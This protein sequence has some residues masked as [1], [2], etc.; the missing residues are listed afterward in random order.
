MIIGFLNPPFIMHEIM[1]YA[2]NTRARLCAGIDV[3]LF[4]LRKRILAARARLDMAANKA[5]GCIPRNLYMTKK[6]HWVR[7]KNR[8]RTL[9]TLRRLMK[10]RSSPRV[11]SGP[12]PESINERDMADRDVRKRMGITLK[13]IILYHTI[14]K[15][16]IWSIGPFP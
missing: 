12:M 1:M 14:Q 2:E 15:R 4:F 3:R 8:D 13:K 7:K 5:R 16:R 9:M 10:K 6:R 11:S